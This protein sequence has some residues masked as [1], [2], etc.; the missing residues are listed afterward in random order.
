MRLG[1]DRFHVV[2]RTRSIIDMGQHHDGDV[3]A[4]ILDAL[5][6]FQAMTLAQQRGQ[7]F[8]H[9]K[10]GREIAAFRQDRLAARIARQ[11]I[12]QNF[13]Q[14]DRGGVAHAHRVCLGA[15]QLG[16]LVAHAPR[17]IDP[18]MF[19]PRR[20][21][22]AAPFVAHDVLQA[23]GRGARQSAQRVAVQ[24]NRPRR[25]AEQMARGR[26]RVGRIHRLGIGAG[27]QRRGE[28][29]RPRARRHQMKPSAS[30]CDRRLAKAAGSSSL[31]PSTIRAWS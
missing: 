8:G 30:A 13:E 9:I 19:V 10:I 18:A 4:N 12:G 16:D 24:I 28:R 31:S 23:C 17:Q 29:R 5:N 2:H 6:Q 15:D 22:V 25:Q 21:Q 14:R 11:R 20:N 7:T 26:Q 27:R 3:V 1:G